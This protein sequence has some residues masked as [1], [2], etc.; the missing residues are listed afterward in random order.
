[1][2]TGGERLQVMLERLDPVRNMYRYYVIALEPTL[3]GDTALVRQWGRIG[4][5]GASAWSS[6]RIRLRPPRSSRRG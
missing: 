2:D 1:M 3:F 5:Q 4:Q 6:M